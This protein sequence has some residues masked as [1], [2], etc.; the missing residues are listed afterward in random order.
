LPQKGTKGAK[1][2][3]PLFLCILRLFAAKAEGG[4]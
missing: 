1:E 3:T 4:G 2:K